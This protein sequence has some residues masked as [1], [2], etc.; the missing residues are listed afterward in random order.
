LVIYRD[1]RN[2]ILVLLLQLILLDRTAHSATQSHQFGDS[3]EKATA[4]G[5]FI[6]NY[7]F[8]GAINCAEFSQI[9]VVSGKP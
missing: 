8:N 4:M 1:R 5:K 7:D 6:S 9:G 2:Y 3:V